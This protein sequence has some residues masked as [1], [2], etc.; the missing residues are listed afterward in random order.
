MCFGSEFEEAVVCDGFAHPIHEAQVAMDVV[1]GEQAV[2]EHF[3]GVEEVA[4]VA[5]GVAVTAGAGTT[6]FNGEVAGFPC[7]R[8]YWVGA[9]V[10]EGGAVT[11]VACR[12]DAIE[13]IASH[14]NGFS[15]LPEVSETHNVTRAMFG[16]IGD[17]VGNALNN[18]RFG[19]AYTNTANC[20]SVEAVFFHSGEFNG[21]V[22]A[23]MGIFGALYDAEVELTFCTRLF[24]ANAR[25]SES[26]LNASCG[27]GFGRGVGDTLVK[28]HCNI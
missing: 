16:H 12:D 6:R 2:A 9:I 5:T 15:H 18:E 7:A 8:F 10:G 20:E 11:C 23:K 1:E 17:G 22:F 24:E 13:H 25:P 21:T 26:L 4:H 28:E 27:V 3:R 14:T 19:F